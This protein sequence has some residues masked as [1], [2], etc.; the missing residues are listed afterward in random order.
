M[1]LS[2]ADYMTKT[3]SSQPDYNQCKE[4][5][6][7]NN[8]YNGHDHDKY[9]RL[10]YSGGLTVPSLAL[11]DFLFQTFSILHYISP[12]IHEAAKKPSKY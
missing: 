4:K 2:I 6:I 1:A 7:F 12:T 10:L 3:L 11:T 9:L 8:K 5:L